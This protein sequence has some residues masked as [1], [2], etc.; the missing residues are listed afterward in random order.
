MTKAKTD[1][2]QTTL[3]E[4]KTRVYTLMKEYVTVTE[5]LS[6]KL[7]D[8]G[9]YMYVSLG[10][11]KNDISDIFITQ[12]ERAVGVNREKMDK[13]GYQKFRNHCSQI[14]RI[15]FLATLPGRAYEDY[16]ESKRSFT[17][18]YNEA[19]GWNHPAKMK[20]LANIAEG[21][22]ST[23]HMRQRLEKEAAEGVENAKVLAEAV[24]ASG[25]TINKLSEIPDKKDS[26]WTAKPVNTDREWVS[27]GWRI[28]RDDPSIFVR[29]IEVCVNKLILTERVL[30]IVKEELSKLR[31]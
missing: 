16:R 22:E 7:G 26:S 29:L 20:H 8:E 5:N 23:E 17:S 6:W 18:C 1:V 10:Y 11:K 27:E 21:K 31:K 2:K 3:K 4:V 30:T 9:R 28:V 13:K 12:Y 19:M 14:N 25:K 24:A 15:V